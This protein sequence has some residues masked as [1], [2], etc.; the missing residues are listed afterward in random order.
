MTTKILI[1]LAMLTTLT[2]AFADTL[3]GSCT[4]AQT[5]LEI[6][7]YSFSLA[8][9][10]YGDT[11][12]MYSVKVPLKNA[13]NDDYYIYV[14]NTVGLNTWD[15]DLIRVLITPVRYFCNPPVLG[16]D[17][18]LPTPCSRPAGWEKLTKADLKFSPLIGDKL[19]FEDSTA[20][21]AV[22]CKATFN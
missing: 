8:P 21:I 3:T 10:K 5:G 12:D 22:S 19:F 9:S 11:S 16:E 20:Q 1:A 4:I 15:K 18:V 14:T 13:N 6:Q 17:G 7:T 2:S